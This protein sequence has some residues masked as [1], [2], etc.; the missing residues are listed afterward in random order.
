M[1]TLGATFFVVIVAVGCG[2]GNKTAQDPVCHY[3]ANADTDGDGSMSGCHAGPPG[4]I[5]QV[6]N[7]ATINGEDGGVSGGTESCQGQCGAGQYE[8]TSTSV[9]VLGGAI[10]DPAASLSCQGISGPMP[11]NSLSYCCPCAN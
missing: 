7:G 5:C 8:L 10:P 4:Q 6:S 3:P 1:R 9:S 11:S 2:G